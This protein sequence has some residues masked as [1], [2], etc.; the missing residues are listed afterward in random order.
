MTTI[1]TIGHRKW[2]RLLC[3]GLLAHA[4][5]G[6]CAATGAGD[7]FPNRPIRWIVGFPPGGSDD[8]V[9]RTIGGKITERFGQTVIVDNRPGAAGNLATEL[10]ARANPD[11]YTVAIIG[12]ITTASSATLYPKLGYD[13]LKDFT[14]VSIVAAGANALLAH[15]SLPAKS[16]PELVA[17]ARAKPGAI[18]YGSAGTGSL[19]HLSMEL[20]Q[21]LTGME[22]LHVPYKGG[23]PAVVALT[24][25]EVQVG[26]ANVPSAMA[27]IQSK[28]LNVLAVA[29]AQRLDALPGVPTVAEAEFPGFNVTNMFGVIAPAGTPAAIVKLLNAELRAIVRTP[30]VKAK[31]TALGMETAESTPAEFRSVMEAEVARWG[32]VVKDAR[33]TIN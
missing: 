7:S 17:L 4:S 10:A 30:D 12:S 1:T 25:G 26:I 29:S 32:R 20:L 8:V 11:G 2:R 14:F 9:S 23:G 5:F 24:A 15:P 18:R 21:K 3:A 22:L 27:M 6:A 13:V 16:V 31:F 33:I 19:G 28:R